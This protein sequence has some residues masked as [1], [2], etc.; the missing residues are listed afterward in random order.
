MEWGLSSNA[1]LSVTP[2]LLLLLLLLCLAWMILRGSPMWP[3][4]TDST[5][6][7]RF[8]PFS[9]PQESTAGPQTA[10][11]E[12][13]GGPSGQAEGPQVSQSQDREPGRG[14]GVSIRHMLCDNLA[15]A[16]C[17]RTASEAQ[18]VV[19]S[20]ALNVWFPD[21]QQ[22]VLP[23]TSY[24]EHSRL[25]AAAALEDPSPIPRRAREPA[26]Q[27]GE[28]GRGPAAAPSP[29]PTEQPSGH[30][31][32]QERKKRLRFAPEAGQDVGACGEGPGKACVQ[33]DCPGEAGGCHSGD[34]DKAGSSSL[35][36][37][38]GGPVATWTPSPSSLSLQE[39]SEG[40]QREHTSSSTHEGSRPPERDLSSESQEDSSPG[41]RL[42]AKPR[43]SKPLSA[44][45]PV[46][47]TKPQLASQGTQGAFGAGF[48]PADTPFVQGE[49]REALEW[50]LALKRAQHAMGLPVAL[51][52]SLRAF[53][54]LA[55]GPSFQ[56]PPWRDAGL[57]ATRPQVLPFVRVAT[58]R[59]LEQHVKKM[60][61]L[62]RWGLPGRVQG[63][64]RHL[65]PESRG[66]PPAGT[67]SIAWEEEAGAKSQRRGTPNRHMPDRAPMGGSPAPTS[68]P[69]CRVKL[70]I[71][72]GKKSFE[73]GQERFP[74]VVENSRGAGAP[75]GRR[76]PLPRL[77]PRDRSCPQPRRGPSLFLRKKADRVEMNVRSKHIHFLSGLPTLHSESLQEMAPLAPWLPTTPPRAHR[78]TDF[79]PV[80]THFLAP[81]E[82]GQLDA[83]L[84]SKRLQHQWALPRLAQRSLL[85]FLPPAP[86]S[87]PRLASSLY[88]HVTVEMLPGGSVPFVTLETKRRLEDH[89]RSKVIERQWGLPKRVLESLRGF[90]PQ[91]P[92]WGRELEGTSLPPRGERT[93][94]R[95]PSGGARATA[96]PKEHSTEGVRETK[97]PALQRH[98]TQ[99]VLEIHLEWLSAT[100]QPPPARHGRLP[101]TLLPGE[102]ALRPR[103]RELF[104][105]EPAV[106]GALE[107][108]LIH[109]DLMQRWG[110]P[111]LYQ[112]SLSCLFQESPV[113]G[114]PP[115]PPLRD[116][117]G[118]GP[119]FTEALLLGEATWEELEWHVR[120]KQLQ[121]IWGLP[122]LAQ[123]SVRSLLPTVPRLPRQQS[124]PGAVSV[125]LGELL[126]LH[127]ATIQAL[128]R[129]VRKR[130]VSQQWQLPQRVLR[131]LKMLHPGEQPESGTRREAPAWGAK[132]TPRGAQAL[133]RRA[134]AAPPRAQ[135][136]SQLAAKPRGELETHL[137]KKHM[138]QQLG[139]PLVLPGP[140]G[141]QTLSPSRR[142]L[143]RLLPP[144]QKALQPRSD[145][146]PSLSSGDLGLIE[147]AVRGRHL[148][149]LWGGGSEDVGESR[150]GIW[151]APPAQGARPRGAVLEPLEVQTTF[152]GE[153][154]RAALEFHVRSK[155]VQHAWRAPVLVRSSLRAF[156]QEAPEVP[157]QPKIPVHVHIIRQ[158]EL[159]LLP[160]EGLRSLE[161]HVHKRNLQ[162]KW[163]L[164]KRALQA[165]R[166]L[167]PATVGVSDTQHGARSPR[168]RAAP[169][170]RWPPPHPMPPSK[171]LEK[172]ELH[173]DKKCVEAQLGALPGWARHPLRG[174]LPSL[175]PLLPKPIPPSQRPLQARSPFLPFVRA[176]DVDRIELVTRRNHLA[177]LWGLARGY[178]EA[179]G[180]MA[181]GP[182][183]QPLK[184]RRPEQ[185]PP[186]QAPF[187]PEPERGDLELHVRKKRLQHAWGVPG[188][189]QR[190]L[191]GFM[192]GAPSL[193]PLQKTLIQVRP[194]PQE[195]PFLPADLSRCLE[196]HLQGLVR[197]RQW[198][199]PRRILRFVQ[200]LCQ[201]LGLAMSEGHGAPDTQHPPPEGSWQN[202]P[203]SLAEEEWDA[204][205]S[206]RR[207]ASSP[208]GAELFDTCSFEV[209][210]KVHLHIVK[211]SVAVESGI[212]PSVVQLPSQWEPWSVGQPPLTVAP[213][214]DPGPQPC[215]PFLPFAQGEGRLPDRPSP[216]VGR[217]GQSYT[218][219]PGDTATGPPRQPL[220]ARRP[221]PLP[222]P[223]QAPFLPEPERGDLELHVRKKRLQH[224]WGV[225]GLV[226]RS[227]AGFMG[228]APSL[229][230][231]QKTLI[232]VRPGPQEL[233]FLPADLSRCLEQHLQGLVR[234]RQWG[235]PRRILRFVQPLCQD[236]GLAMWEHEAPSPPLSR[237]PPEAVS[238]TLP[239]PP[240]EGDKVF[241]EIQVPFVPAQARGDLELHL[242]K[243][244][245][246]HAWGLPGLIR[247]SLDIFIQRAPSG[248]VLPKTTTAVQPLRKEPQSRHQQLEFH[249][250]QIKVQR[251]WGLPGRVLE[252]LKHLCPNVRLLLPTPEGSEHGEAFPFHPGS[253]DAVGGAAPQRPSGQLSPRKTGMAFSEA[254]TPFLLEQEREA[255]EVHITRKKIHHAWGL[256]NL[257]QKSLKAFLEESPLLPAHPQT[258]LLVCVVP[259]E[260]PFLPRDLAGHLEMHVQKM[261]LQRRWG[262]PRRVLQSLRRLCPG[263]GEEADRAEVPRFG[264]DILGGAGSGSPPVGQGKGP[265]GV[266]HEQDRLLSTVGPAALRKMQQ[267]LAK[268]D[269]EL[270]LQVLP[271]AVTRSR[272]RA[273]PSAGQALPRP[274]RTRSGAQQPR[275]D[276]LP[277][278]HKEEKGRIELAIQRS[279]FAALWGLS[280]RYAEALAGM[281]P[282]SP[283]QFPQRQAAAVVF[284]EEETPFLQED[285][286]D[287]LEKHIRNKAIQHLWGTPR[288]AQRSLVAFMHRPPSLPPHKKAVTGVQ[289]LL[290]ELPFLPLATR[291]HLEHH[292]QRLQQ[293][294]Q[295]GLPGRVLNSLK[296]FCPP[297]SGVT[298]LLSQ[299]DE[300]EEE[301]A[302][303]KTRLM[304]IPSEQERAMRDHLDKKHSEIQAEASLR[305]TQAQPRKME[306]VGRSHLPS[307]IHGGQTGPPKGDASQLLLPPNA[308][309]GSG[310]RAKDEHPASAWGLPR[311]GVEP[312]IKTALP[313]HLPA[314]PSEATFWLQETE[315]P[316]LQEEEKQRL[317]LHLKRKRLQHQ[318]GLPVAIGRSLQAFAP[319][320]LAPPPAPHRASQAIAIRGE[321]PFLFTALGWKELEDSVKKMLVQRQWGLPR[322]IRRSLWAWSPAALAGTDLPSNQ[323][324]DGL[325]KSVG[326]DSHPHDR[327]GEEA[328]PAPRAARPAG[329]TKN[330]PG[331]TGLATA[332]GKDKGPLEGKGASRGPKAPQTE[333]HQSLAVGG[334]PPVEKE[335]V[336]SQ[337]PQSSGEAAPGDKRAQR[338][339]AEGR[340]SGSPQGL[341]EASLTEGPKTTEKAATEAE[342]EQTDRPL[343]IAS[344][345]PQATQETSIAQQHSKE[346]TDGSTASETQ[347]APEEKG[348]TRPRDG[349]EGSTPTGT[350]PATETGA[351]RPR[352]VKE[353]ST[354]TG[355]QP[356]TETGATRP[357][358][359]KEGS[360]PTGTQPATETGATR[361]LDGKEGST[362]TGTQPATETGA[363]RPWD[364][365][366]GST[367][368][369][370][371]PATE[372]GATQPRDGKEGS[373]PSGMQP[374]PEEMGATR[375][376]DEKE[377]S[378]PTG[379]QPATETGATRP[380]DG[381]EGSTPTATQ[382][383]TETGATRP[384]DEKEG[385]TPTGTQ[386][387]T[388]KGAT[389]PRD[390]K[391]GSTPTGTQPATE[392]TGATWP[393]DGKEGSTPTATQPATEETG[394]TWPRDGK[395]GSIP[396][397][398]Q[399]AT[400]TGATWP[401]D[402]KEESIPT[403][404]Q[405]AT[406]TGATWPRD[407]KE[408]IPTGTQPATET[409]TTWPRDGKEGS[410]PTGTQP[411]TETGATRPWDGKEG[412]IPTGTQPATEMGA[413]Q[414]RDGKEGSTPTATQP[415]TET[416][417][418]RPWDGKEGSIPTGTQPATEMG[419]TQPRDGKEGSTPT[420]TQPA[421][422]TGATRPWDGKEGSTPSGMQPAPEE[423]GATRP[424]DVKK[425]SIPTGTQ[426]AT[427][428]GA[429]QP[430]DGKEGSIPTGTQPTPEEM[431]ATRPRDVKKVSIS[432]SQSAPEEMKT[433]CPLAL[434]MTGAEHPHASGAM[435]VT[436]EPPWPTEEKGTDPERSGQAVA[437]ALRGE[438]P[439]KISALY[440]TELW[441]RIGSGGEIGSPVAPARSPIT[442]FPQFQPPVGIPERGGGYE[443]KLAGPPQA[444]PRSEGSPWQE[445]PGQRSS[446]RI[447]FPNV[448]PEQ[449]WGISG[450]R[451]ELRRRPCPPQAAPP[452]RSP[453]VPRPGHDRA[454]DPQELSRPARKGEPDRSTSAE[455]S[456]GQKG[457]I[458]HQLDGG[459]QRKVPVWHS[460]CP[461]CQCHLE[462][463]PRDIAFFCETCADQR[464]PQQ[465]F[466]D[467][468]WAEGAETT[469]PAS[470]TEDEA[471]PPSV[472]SAES[473]TDISLLGQ[474]ASRERLHRPSGGEVSHLL[475]T[476]VAQKAL[477]PFAL[478]PRVICSHSRYREAVAR[479]H[480]QKA[481]A[482]REPPWVG[483]EDTGE[484][485]SSQ[486][487]GATAGD[488]EA[489]APGLV[490]AGDTQE[491]ATESPACE[492]PS[493][494]SWHPPQPP[495]SSRVSAEPPARGG[496]RSPEEEGGSSGKASGE[497][498]PEHESS[499]TTWEAGDD[500]PAPPSDW[501]DSDVEEERA[502]GQ[503]TS[504]PLAPGPEASG[505]SPGPS[506]GHSSL[507][508][509]GWSQFST[510]WE[511]VR[512]GDWNSDSVAS[513][514]QGPAQE[515]AGRDP[516][517]L[518]R[519]R[520][521][522]RAREEGAAC[523]HDRDADRRLLIIASILDKKL[524][525]QQG[526]LTWLESQGGQ[527]PGWRKRSSLST[528]LQGHLPRGR[529]GGLPS[530][531]QTEGKAHRRAGRLLP[532]SQPSAAERRGRPLRSSPSSSVSL[533]KP[534]RPH[535]GEQRSP[536]LE[537]ELPRD[538]RQRKPCQER[539]AEGGEGRTGGH[540]R[541]RLR[542]WGRGPGKRDRLAASQEDRTSSEAP[543]SG[544][545]GGR[546]FLAQGWWLQ[547]REQ[548]STGRLC[549][550]SRTVSRTQHPVDTGLD[551]KGTRPDH[552]PEGQEGE[553]PTENSQGVAGSFGRGKDTR[554]EKRGPICAERVPPRPRDGQLLSGQAS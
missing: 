210:E 259:Q 431:G 509:E 470:A 24:V 437:G 459:L 23:S 171:A 38:E 469:P 360:T 67:L 185:A 252:S 404:T 80:A 540:W 527:R 147:W 363:T 36:K 481:R 296:A 34:R 138:A 499:W 101:K 418:T 401:R 457:Q 313:A 114:A 397:G 339:Q 72:V 151:P 166:P 158:L 494:H 74:R 69:Y 347:P 123:R 229:S 95:P 269:L 282:G 332:E 292:V 184:A 146:C 406:E 278:L 240:G 213:L 307:L 430:R 525:L 284:L 353:G 53:Q 203:E 541:W 116:R 21:S 18:R 3:K 294:R 412:S 289:P 190:S 452:S 223:D 265:V 413:T 389:R 508:A 214:G 215:R 337:S 464:P 195:L 145:F 287:A 367:P 512:V 438:I 478:P 341:K 303:R 467:P 274:I 343:R 237:S 91:P 498:W 538:G 338:R 249:I 543:V 491:G 22:P 503:P 400:E 362:P 290:P 504:S 421:T 56:W 216:S 264:G 340:A 201:D 351:T 128:E 132:R 547:R 73:V 124:G 300:E 157:A 169:T 336:D 150:A 5:T 187:L 235:L 358:D 376:R 473:T 379:T 317:E 330:G 98:V 507:F 209:L 295:W 17:E 173:L 474:E 137:A 529:Q 388:E 161:F 369:G 422:E 253:T 423:M 218:E 25:P 306:A 271:R 118:P 92:P 257:V 142:A 191:A 111:T 244:R 183:C 81:C 381:K 505:P 403:G 144:G 395:E 310:Q 42:P 444:R 432:E 207:R 261:N 76:E 518:S 208:R 382:P 55:P 365:K 27:G 475:C 224:A 54:P 283:P 14:V 416:G 451:L 461:P 61:H 66:P 62:K 534:A 521:R 322:R 113:P 435:K 270:Q 349:K 2:V 409:G 266:T 172:M 314:P 28:T 348:A 383:A 16:V 153:Q 78:P 366:E 326:S 272:Q 100:T 79:G 82:R 329:D 549:R 44:A 131:S 117:R 530:G 71:H 273:A 520:G 242:R 52:R 316:F 179:V 519:A 357:R 484:G 182:P 506:S 57:V 396:T 550:S 104:F 75:E 47:K 393:Q 130:I 199:L 318:W 247:R 267:H 408:S 48:S 139:S 220:K 141:G 68:L 501:M 539:G 465:Q 19:R 301:Q 398:T 454:P 510:E 251:Q 65:Q 50:H 177:S 255:L 485:G 468:A 149:S 35:S 320:P 204:T 385:S 502:G 447:R 170:P 544:S 522:G 328:L 500:F 176:E 279:H 477:G 516:G 378:K 225:P 87:A 458:L 417:A 545:R 49:V 20:K 126:F 86:G 148:A 359:V 88:I 51:L 217:L 424:R 554:E 514:S 411:G 6:W 331:A 40:S 85:Q 386:P 535:P 471:Q 377:G 523:S 275:R 43:R 175:R 263:P 352:D 364:G 254:S 96:P 297:A 321:K 219:A 174:P 312:P 241:S 533:G 63:A 487:H 167:G 309:D 285:H 420:A 115:L 546:R 41:M 361:P 462:T 315:A 186:E 10:G 221:G 402:G 466:P 258:H 293:Q 77:T 333:E 526:L 162:Q 30:G 84:L 368:T 102:G 374:A 455:T 26:P 345:S 106:L 262:M 154:E 206:L 380:R 425:V 1:A 335:G 394:A 323:E 239:S 11:G 232:Q 97:H 227:L 281:A 136:L 433:T 31:E 198:G 230:P 456:P 472:S 552:Q 160:P 197:Q 119:G 434:P 121:H 446:L 200:P 222:S 531:A 163:G 194:G 12:G 202:R 407:G 189:V 193:S 443:R 46:Q 426:P 60:V 463:Y 445:K 342:H 495:Q 392:E 181:P 286:R 528:E 536:R 302:Q 308:E 45:P 226:Q 453:R 236:L 8:L 248:T 553:L 355:T 391:E 159:L 260:L 105:L 238:V 436:R 103:P 387:A 143:P 442:P 513:G 439:Q 245:L 448:M 211:K 496:R 228:G 99:K 108:N 33:A 542:L 268:K 13:T 370:T 7:R 89:V 517:G 373:T 291:S 205:G 58:R 356:A 532:G 480:R 156:M 490:P 497:P 107:L 122:V 298:A 319:P 305:L 346:V 410:I 489:Q 327:G 15:C 29:C 334:Q 375:P 134:S 196:Q 488:E 311:K 460:V 94:P 140:A 133:K 405:P 390:G 551:P 482:Q 155:K 325:E 428:M 256:P 110:L 90:M 212:F 476:H 4:W 511:E 399:P 32:Q 152:L 524:R 449:Y 109:Q 64:L 304:D 178:V 479:Q 492:G 234:Q 415:A 135:S 427:E 277:F 280:L 344:G 537:E 350:Q 440:R 83:H 192:G 371:Q 246:Q 288:L 276:F 250:Q 93:P 70:Q 127:K 515:A 299:R 414:P 372:T 429:S 450:E 188:L 548:G 493:G 9:G 243:K 39:S 419:A 231:L 165:L 486:G 384:R 483:W 233:P 168:R 180:A 112:K 59:R 164:P 120:R 129:N 441:V 125:L 37:E 324:E 354:P